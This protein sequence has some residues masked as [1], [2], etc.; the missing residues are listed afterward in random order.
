LGRRCRRPGLLR[1]RRWGCGGELDR[2][3]ALQS[4][5]W[6]VDHP[7]RRGETGRHLDAI[8]EIPAELDGF[9]CH[10]V[11]IAK[12]RDLRTMVA[13]DQRRGRYAHHV[14]VA[15][16]LKMDLAIGTWRELVVRIV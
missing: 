13:R 7:I 3:A 11:A 4:F 6:T 16:D 15:R 14:R 1:G 2:I 8:T 10:F 5:G 12:Q 9:E